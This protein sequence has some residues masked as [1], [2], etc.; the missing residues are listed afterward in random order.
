MAQNRAAQGDLAMKSDLS[1]FALDRS[2]RRQSGPGRHGRICP[3]CLAAQLV[4]SDLDWVRAP[5]S[6]YLR[7]EYGWIVKTAYFGLG[8]SLV[9][10]GLGYHRALS[11]TARSGAPFLL[12]ALRW[13]GAGRHGAGR[14]RLA[15]RAPRAGG[16]CAQPGR[17]HGIPVRHDGH[18]AAVLVVRGRTRM[19]TPFAVA[20]T[21][22]AVCFCRPVV[23]IPSRMIGPVAC[24]RKS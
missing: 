4:R 18:A 2:P 16:V 19:A 20:F 8:A 9:L 21:L 11:A 6:S 3:V 15:D 10:L 14:L 12:F 1:A 23:C 13:R 5:L 7:G 24:A 22:A 17:R